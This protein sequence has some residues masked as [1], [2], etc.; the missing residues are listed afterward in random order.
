MLL[1]AYL[2]MTLGML[3]AGETGPLPGLVKPPPLLEGDT[4]AL[5][6]P[7]S[8]LSESLVRQA[9]ANLERRGYRVRLAVLPGRERGYLAADD[10]TRAR[11]LNDLLRDGGVKAIICLR[12]GYGSPRILDRIDY[13][14]LRRQPKIII[15]YSDITALLLAIHRKAGVVCFHGP[16][17]KEWGLGRGI[18]PYSEQYY[19]SLL[20]AGTA[21]IEDWGGKRARGMKSPTTLVGGTAVGRL[22]G[23]NLSLISALM[24]T[25]YEID[26]RNSILFLEEVA[27][28]PFRVDRMLNQLR[29]AGKL[30]EVHG[31][32]LGGFPACD[33]RD[34]DGDLPLE[35]VFRDYFEPLG[36]PVLADF[37]AGHVPDQA[38]LPLGVVVRL[39]ATEGTL[40][41][42]ESPV[43][44]EERLPPSPDPN[45]FDAL[46]QD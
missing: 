14:T 21:P 11:A 36:V 5:V 43:A 20:A 13:A 24:G 44:A 34:P 22:I 41:L 27:E 45:D 6:A 1:S 15:G 8:P 28:K 31:V 38:L 23:G 29:L 10:A 40:T 26:T 2:A 33:A 18:S 3:V 30:K 25:P 37:P 17:G 42:L 4:I 39:N 16:M 9:V 7:A 35:T 46:E 12:G 19:W 32:L